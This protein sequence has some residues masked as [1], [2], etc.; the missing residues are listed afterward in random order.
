MIK[1]YAHKGI[2]QFD[3]VVGNQHLL[4]IMSKRVIKK[5]TNDEELV[6]ISMRAEGK[7]A[8]EISKKLNRS[9]YSIN[10]RIRKLIN[11]CR[12]E[13][14]ETHSAPVD[15]DKIGE[16]VSKNPGNL[17][18]AF[19]QYATKYGCSVR[20]VSNAYYSRTRSKKQ[21]VKDRGT[22]FTVVGKNGHTVNNSKVTNNIKRSNLWSKMKDWLLS[23][24]LS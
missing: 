13:L 16:Y 1:Q 2:I 22:L 20:T 12:V 4:Y 8:E 10:G 11:E 5:W 21:R 3:S 17:Q 23:S 15:Y 14:K 7:T 18:K 24:L 9:V 6:I 19:R